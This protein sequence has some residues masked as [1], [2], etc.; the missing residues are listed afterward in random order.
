MTAFRARL[1]AAARARIPASAR[2]L[3]GLTT[4]TA[5]RFG[6]ASRADRLIFLPAYAGVVAP[7]VT[8]CRPCSAAALNI[9]MSQGVNRG[10]DA[11]FSVYCRPTAWSIPMRPPSGELIGTLSQVFL[12]ER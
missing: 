6:L 5:H 10:G 9:S 8:A 7:A 2:W 11:V 4:S 1:A 3:T 12:R